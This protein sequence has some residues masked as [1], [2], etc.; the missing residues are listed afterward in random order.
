M[1]NKSEALK[2]LRE[3]SMIEAWK[4]AY[5]GVEVNSVAVVDLRANPNS[6]EVYHAAA[7]ILGITG[8]FQVSRCF[9]TTPDNRLLTVLS[10]GDRDMASELESEGLK[11]IRTETRHDSST[12]L[13]VPLP[14][15]YI[16]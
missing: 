4:A 8:P 1:D 16:K 15:A 7:T 10:L 5:D 14:A 13:S 2:I 3:H 6:M 11:V 12:K 9:T